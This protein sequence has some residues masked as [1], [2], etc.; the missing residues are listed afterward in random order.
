MP[1]PHLP[2]ARRT[3][4][5]GSA[6][7]AAPSLLPRLA[8]AAAPPPTATTPPPPA[9][10]GALA[11]NAPP[12][13]EPLI[14]LGSSGLLV[15]PLGIG[16]WAWGDKTAYW[17]YGTAE[18]GRAD[19]ETAF[20][21]LLARGE[22][23]I[24]TAEAYGFGES[25]RLIGQFAGA[26]GKRPVI[27]TK[28]APLPWRRGPDT[29]VAALRASLTRLQLERV[30][31]YQI[32]WPGLLGTTDG[33]VAGL[34]D[35]VDLGL[36]AAGG[37]SNFKPERVTAAAAALTARGHALAS[38]QIQFSLL[39]RGAEVEDTVAATR[40]AGAT[41]I[42]Y[43]PLAQGLLTGK[44]SA[45]NLP[46]T[47]PRVATI[48]AARVAE[49]QPLIDAMRAVGSEHGGKTPAQVALNWCIAKG[50]VP[51][52][53]AKNARQA[54]E[55][56]GALGWRVTAAEV[57]ELDAVSRKVPQGLGFPTEKW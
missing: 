28:F 45:D 46:K 15:P 39:Y 25:E 41:V 31:L 30:G 49:V 53:G 17:G 23:L 38:N 48:T 54:A 24:D 32:H 11:W 1:T 5:L 2:V 13:A 56:A 4:L 42:A 10:D 52:P 21:E 12:P 22:A 19:C 18:F 27:A 50:T 37:V 43:S 7:S 40:A 14:Q 34:C 29:V 33:Y 57:E 44:F 55:A 36:T 3:V 8:T 6:A 47:G 51:I 16:A 9:Q 26:A 20:N 35:C